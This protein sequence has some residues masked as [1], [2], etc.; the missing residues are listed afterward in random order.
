MFHLR[1]VSA[2]RQAENKHC[3]EL[4]GGGIARKHIQDYDPRCVGR[5]YNDFMM[6][7][8]VFLI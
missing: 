6:I 2:Q 7:L 5:A 4:Y 3:A 8:S 1:A